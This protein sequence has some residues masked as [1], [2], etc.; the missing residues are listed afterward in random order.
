MT[1]TTMA[2]R[3]AQRPARPA[4]TW[5]TLATLA[6]AIALLVYMQVFLV[7][8]LMPPIALMFGVPALIFA[9]LVGAIRRPWA[10][11][12]GALYWLLFLAANAPYLGHDLA[13]PEF[14]SN[15]S[16]SVTLLIPA[17]AGVAAGIGA[18]VQNYRARGSAS[19]ETDGRRVPRWFSSG[20][21]ALAALGLGAILVA[22]IAPAGASTG[23][24]AET[25][26]GLPA[27]TSAQHQFDQTELRAKAG[28]TVALRLEN[29]D[30]AGHS[31]DIDELDIHVSMPPGQPALALFKVST[32][33][34]YTFYCSV[35]G[36]RDAGMVGT[37]IVEP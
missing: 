37:L 23:V 31:F 2:A 26:A 34:T 25:L 32:P 29:Q 35:P 13:H 14:F 22:A 4:L 12:L 24:S 7:R 19:P 30:A 6:A 33:G 15:F 3:A 8:A 9:A 36:H 5:W 10:P 16:F 28:E 21:L 11:V 18:A 20:L 1:T 27:L 17:V